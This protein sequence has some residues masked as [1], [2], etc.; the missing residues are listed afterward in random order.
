MSLAADCRDRPLVTPQR[1][2]TA[3]ARAAADGSG[4]CRSPSTCLSHWPMRFQLAKMR[5]TVLDKRRTQSDR[6]RDRAQDADDALHREAVAHGGTAQSAT[7][8]CFPSFMTS[9]A[10]SGGDL[11]ARIPRAAP[12]RRSRPKLFDP[13]MHF[14]HDG[15]HHIETWTRQTDERPA[16]VAST[17]Q[18]CGAARRIVAAITR[19]RCQGIPP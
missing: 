1:L 16:P 17:S 3:Q 12:P 6:R 8:I 13:A 18:Y 10:V 5:L 15:P 19:T 7:T 14:I 4:R 9:S 11:R 2:P